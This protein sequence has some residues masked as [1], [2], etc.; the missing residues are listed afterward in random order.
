MDRPFVD[1]VCISFDYIDILNILLSWSMHS[2]FRHGGF[3]FDGENSKKLVFIF[4]VEVS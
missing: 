2:S 3:S 1:K 4:V